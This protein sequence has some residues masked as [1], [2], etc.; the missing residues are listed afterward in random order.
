MQAGSAAN[1]NHTLGDI[2][3]ASRHISCITNVQIGYSTDTP[4]EK[5]RQLQRSLAGEYVLP[6]DLRSSLTALRRRNAAAED[7]AKKENMNEQED[8]EEKEKKTNEA[9]LHET[10][11]LQ[12]NNPKEEEEQTKKTRSLK[13]QILKNLELAERMKVVVLE[14]TATHNAEVARIDAKIMGWNDILCSID[15]LYCLDLFGYGDGYL[16]EIKMTLSKLIEMPRIARCE[17]LP[18]VDLTKLVGYTGTSK[19]GKHST[20][21]MMSFLR[22][23]NFD[24]LRKITRL[25]AK[26]RKNDA[27]DD[28]EEEEEEEQSKKKKKRSKQMKGR[29]SPRH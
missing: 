20:R 25:A 9:R 27:E 10:P 11:I 18:R 15:G 29:R 3:S 7:G 28:E 6:G 23:N 16:P 14:K 2:A 26:K 12:N 8:K 1:P 24:H 17:L 21:N 13:G 19:S 22:T 4:T 5:E